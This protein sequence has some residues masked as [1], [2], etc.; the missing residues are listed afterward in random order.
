MPLQSRL[1]Q[2]RARFE[3]GAP[4]GFN[5]LRVGE[6]LRRPVTDLNAAGVVDPA[7]KVGDI[8][9]D[10]RLE[11][12]RGR[13]WSS[14]ALR[15]RGPLV[16]IFCRGVRGPSGSIELQ[17]LQDVSPEIQKRGAGL[18]AISPQAAESGGRAQAEN[19]RT[20]PLLIDLENTTGAAYG[21]RWKQ[22]DDL[23]DLHR[24]LFETDLEAFSPDGGWTLPLRSRFVIGDG[25]RVFHAD[26]SAGPTQ[27]LRPEDLLAAIDAARDAG[28]GRSSA[29]AGGG[30]FRRHP[31]H[32]DSGPSG[33]RL[34]PAF[35]DDRAALG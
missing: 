8:A 7:L 15:R 13:L 34:R 29:G 31:L 1:D 14:R 18:V 21:V 19:A 24:S 5:T 16:V 28:P 9:S 23:M 22:L 17:A 10:F 27:Q 33:G 6:I 32:R 30:A 12:T 26:I 4:P 11:D 35:S 3:G 2:F 20:F 25:G